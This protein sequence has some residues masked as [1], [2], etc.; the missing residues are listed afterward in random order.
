[1]TV[2]NSV[3]SRNAR[4]DAFETAVGV[5]AILKIR[6][7]AQPANCAAADSGTSLITINLPSDWLAAAANGVKS[8]NG[9]W[10]GTGEAE[11]ICG[12]YRIYASDG[13]TCHEQGSVSEADGG[14]DMIVSNVNVT[15]GQPISVTSYNRT[16]GNA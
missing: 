1:M 12:H 3:A 11:G 8:K 16:A 15:V 7:G 13:T 2:Q 5:S 9:T 14:G 10:E 4:L 6:T